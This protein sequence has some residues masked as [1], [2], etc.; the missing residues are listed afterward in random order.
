M[1]VA[2]V[3]PGVAR[4]GADDAECGRS[5]RRA[6]L[7]RAAD[8]H[9]ARLLN[10]RARHRRDA[11]R[12]LGGDRALRRPQRSVAAPRDA[13]RM[14]SPIEPETLPV[15]RSARRLMVSGSLSGGAA[16]KEAAKLEKAADSYIDGLGNEVQVE[17]AKYA[18]AHRTGDR[19]M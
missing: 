11:P 16:N 3:V 4:A 15:L 18:I 5:A 14:L 8:L 2:A 12:K 10:G 7:D 13:Q 1:D 9:L 17:K 6:L 19:A